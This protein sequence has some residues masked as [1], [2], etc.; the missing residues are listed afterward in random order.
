MVHVHTFESCLAGIVLGRSLRGTDVYV[1]FGRG[2]DPSD[3]HEIHYLADPDDRHSS[4][5]WHW[6]DTCPWD[7]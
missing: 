3:R 4:F 5:T 2:P 1:L 7:R 6:P